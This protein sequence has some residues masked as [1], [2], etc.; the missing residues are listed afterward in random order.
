MVLKM[1]ATEIVR[2]GIEIVSLA[3][4]EECRKIL[5]RKKK[6]RPRRW[7]VK[8]WIQRREQLGASTQLLV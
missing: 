2:F 1:S 5:E 4:A 7:W 6:R 8:P 3:L